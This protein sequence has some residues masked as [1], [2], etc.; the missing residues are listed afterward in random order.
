MIII[1][2][3]QSLSAKNS[4]LTFIGLIW[5]WWYVFFIN[6]YDRLTFKQQYERKKKK[7]DD[8]IAVVPQAFS[9]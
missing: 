4:L 9:N 5:C 1:E 2:Q 8:N 7:D 3:V 6:D